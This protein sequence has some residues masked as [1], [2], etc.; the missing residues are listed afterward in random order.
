MQHLSYRGTRFSTD[1]PRL[2]QF[3]VMQ[4]HCYQVLTKSK[5]KEIV[6]FF[7]STK[8]NLA[9]MK[10]HWYESGRRTLLG[11]NT[12]GGAVMLWPT[13]FHC[14]GVRSSTGLAS[15]THIA[16]CIYTVY[17]VY[18][19]PRSVPGLPECNHC[20]RPCLHVL[21]WQ[22][23]L[24]YIVTLQY[25]RSTFHWNTVLTRSSSRYQNL[26]EHRIINTHRDRTKLTLLLLH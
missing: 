10:A 17:T 15:Y 6:T 11:D 13:Q 20:G 5:K 9:G 21:Y 2:T 19:Q 7:K 12:G 16:N 18:T 4:F 14:F 8:K 3:Q 22:K 26:Q 24:S 1:T 23:P 25:A